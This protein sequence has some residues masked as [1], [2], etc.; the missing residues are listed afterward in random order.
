MNWPQ[1]V[2]NIKKEEKRGEDTGGSR[3]SLVSRGSREEL[4]ALPESWVTCGQDVLFTCME[5]PK[6][7]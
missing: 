3:A 2:I 6:N 5:M 1:W 4:G 7:K